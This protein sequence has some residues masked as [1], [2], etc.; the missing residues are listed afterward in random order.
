MSMQQVKNYF[1]L[2]DEQMEVVEM[3]KIKDEMKQFQQALKDN[4]LI[5][6]RELAQNFGWSV[7][8]TKDQLYHW[9]YHADEV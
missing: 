4:E 1:D 9:M 8:Q 5:E 3:K 2:T 6:A 7:E